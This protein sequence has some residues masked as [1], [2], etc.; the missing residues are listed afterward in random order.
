MAYMWNLY[1]RHI[2]KLESEITSIIYQTDSTPI[3]TRFQSWNLFGVQYGIVHPQSRV[4]SDSSR[5]RT[6]FQPDSKVG[7]ELEYQYGIVHPEILSPLFKV[8]L[9]QTRFQSWNWIGVQYGIVHPQSRVGSDSS[10]IRTGFQ[11]DSKVGIELE[12]STGQFIHS[13]LFKVDLV[14]IPVGF[15]LDLN[16]IP[17]GFQLDSKVGIELELQYMIFHPEISMPH[18]SK[19]GWFIFHSDSKRD[20]NW[21]QKLELNWS[22][23]HDIS[24]RDLYASFLQVGWFIFHS[25]SNLIPTGFQSW[26]WIGVQYI[27]FHPETSM[28]HFYKSCWF[29]FHSDSNWIPKLELNWSTVHDII[30]SPLFLIILKSGWFI[31]H[32]DSNWIPKLELN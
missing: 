24:S 21:I 32:S 6:G 2:P 12:Y 10:H 20:S 30:Q 26:N 23:V 3:P 28:P 19:S 27:I 22:T 25:D 31:F 18:F 8:G 29:I 4:G 17:T 5:I 7:I 16:W 1:W 14:Q 13:P 9:V 15:E 11:P